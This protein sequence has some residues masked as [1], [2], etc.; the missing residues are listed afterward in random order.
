MRIC[1]GRIP[2]CVV[3]LAAEFYSIL[4]VASLR[5]INLNRDDVSQLSYN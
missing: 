3:D 5:T 1:Y 2:K 4:F